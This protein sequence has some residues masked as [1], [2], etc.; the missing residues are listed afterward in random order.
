M[1]IIIP[2]KEQD[3]EWKLH[4]ELSLRSSNVPMDFFLP[5]LASGQDLLTKILALHV[6]LS[7]WF[8]ADI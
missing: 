8:F 3:D 5:Y 6:F 4:A 1:V 7:V 2:R